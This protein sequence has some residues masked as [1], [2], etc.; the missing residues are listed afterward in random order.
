MQNVDLLISARWVIPV[1]PDSKVL[2]LHSITIRDGK[3]VKVLPTAEAEKEYHATEVVDLPSHAVFPGFVN[4]HTHAAMTLFRGL[5]D[6]LP[7]MQWLEKH[8]WPA[9]AKWVSDE[10]VADGARLAMAEMIR[11]GTTCF[12][13]M[14][15]FAED[16]AHVARE[17]RMRAS[18]GMIML[19]FPS[20]YAQ[21]WDEYLEKG[22]KLHDDLRNSQLVSTTFAPHAPY[23]VSDEPLAKISTL[24]N[25]LNRPVHIHVHETA[26]EVAE[27]EK[28]TRMRP[29]AR[30]D[31][32]DLVNPNLLAV[33]FTETTPDEIRLLADNNA[34]VVHCPESNLKLGSGFCPVVDLIDAGVNVALGTDGAASNN[35]LDMLGELR[36]AALLAKGINSDA[37]ALPAHTVL[38]M[39]TLNGARALGLDQITGSL[40]PGKMAD[41]IAFDLSA[42]ST[43]PVYD[44]MSQVVYAASRDQ[45]TDVWVAGQRLLK[46]RTLTTIDEARVLNKAGEWRDKIASSRSDN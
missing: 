25:E 28:A 17:V 42:A 32:L 27:A 45:V 1:E 40:V 44:P 5:A 35:D 22:L 21:S 19:D 46:E 14:Y 36:T 30:L 2:D 34:S 23:S 26:A 20:T 33:H 10:F 11:G 16:V 3:I 39:A 18:V 29:L 9:E 12:N 43:Q 8:I 4:A 7:L 13:D 15:F 31:K 41:M 38:K 37:T 6:D 24:N